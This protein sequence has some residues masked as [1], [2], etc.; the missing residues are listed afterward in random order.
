MKRVP[1]SIRLKEEIEGLLGTSETA[2]ATEEAPMVGFVGRLARYML[3]VAIEAEAT[4]FLGRGHY[5][6]G[7]RERVGWRNGYEPKHV[8][9]EAGGLELAVPQLCGTEEAVRP[10]VGDRAGRGAA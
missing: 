4:A 10:T 3:Q 9:T 7:D 5:R 6:R 8:Q 1:P 2:V